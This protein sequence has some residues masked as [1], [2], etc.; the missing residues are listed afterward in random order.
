M[1]SLV[2]WWLVWDFLTCLEPFSLLALLK[3]S[4][5]QGMF[6]M[7]LQ[8]AV[9]NSALI[10]PS[11]LCRASRLSQVRDQGLLSLSWERTQFCTGLCLQI[12]KN[13]LEV[14]KS[15][16]GH[17]IIQLFKFFG[18]LLICPTIS[19]TLGS[20][21]ILKLLV[22]FNQRPWGEAILTEQALN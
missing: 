2:C 22:I 10:F 18:Q 3:G 7:F 8:K 21:Q 14:F 9:C 15:P 12:P 4:A 17:F 20:W 11:G 1:E 6:S 16:Y 5:H 13:I 19:T